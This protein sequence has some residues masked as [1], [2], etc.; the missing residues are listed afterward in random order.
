MDRRE[1]LKILAMASGSLVALPSWALGWDKKSVALRS[2]VFTADEESLIS[3]VS[4]TIIPEKN[5]VGALPVGVDNFLVRLLDQCY[6]TDVQ[7][8]VK[9]QLKQLDE[10]ANQ[11]AGNRFSACSQEERETLLL[12][13]SDSEDKNK[14]AF[15]DLMKSETIR[16]FR[17]SQVVMEEFLGYELMP[18]EYNGAAN[19]NV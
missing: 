19:V 5:S 6:E 11:T 15:F 2:T 13:F 14:Q 10:S 16:G 3:A 17:T 8:N 4:D 1:A 9:N 18:G 7:N 12:A